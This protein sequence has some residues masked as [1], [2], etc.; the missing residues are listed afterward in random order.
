MNEKL[1]RKIPKNVLPESS[2]HL[3]CIDEP[4]ISIEDLDPSLIISEPKYYL[5]GIKGAPEQCYLRKSVGQ[6]LI[7]AAELLPLGYKLK[8]YDGWRP[9]E[10]Q[11]ELYWEFYNR[12]NMEPESQGL[13]EEEVMAK[14]TIFVAYPSIEPQTMSTH[15]TGGAVDLTIVDSEGKEL[16]MG[17]V[18]DD[19]TERAHTH[20]FEDTNC[21]TIKI[22]RRLLYNCMISTGFTNLPSEWWHYD[23]GDRYWGFYKGRDSIYSG[24]SEL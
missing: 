7:D 21:E 10:V 16:D 1:Y 19:F 11:V 3:I 15:L 23:F 14:T 6:M 13:S 8:I 20:Y 12:I 5:S 4:L 9:Y 22:N 24:I 18:F 2:V 17:T